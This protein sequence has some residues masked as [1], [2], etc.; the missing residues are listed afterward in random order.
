M[1]QYLKLQKYSTKVLKDNKI[2]VD[3]DDYFKVTE[4]I[5][6]YFDAVIFNVV[7]IM[8]LISILNNSGK[9]DRQTLDASKEYIESKCKFFYKQVPTNMSGGSRMGS[10]T[11]LG[12]PE[13]MYSESNSTADVMLADFENGVARPELAMTGGAKASSMVGTYITKVLKYHGLTASKEIKEEL[14]SMVMMHVNCLV[15]KL[16]ESKGKLTLKKLN[17]IVKK[18]N[19]LHPMK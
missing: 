12:K 18:S 9:I 2:A 6:I 10:A 5:A 11:F 1:E 14:C 4:Q 17:A 7:S 8:C 15:Q 19:I 3:Q 16:K 13:Q